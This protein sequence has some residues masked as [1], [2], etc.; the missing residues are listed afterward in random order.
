MPS[1]VLLHGIWNPAWWLLPLARRLRREGFEVQLFGYN[2][3]LAGPDAAV[4]ALVRYLGRLGGG[5]VSLVGHSLGGLVA[6]EA[7]RRGAPGVEKIV[8]LGSPL[9][10]SAAARALC[11]H[12]GCAWLLGRSRALLLEGV[13]PW[14]GK[15]AV[16]MI[17]GRRAAGLGRL[18]AG[19]GES[20]G[21]VA[22]AETRLPG[23][24]DHC[25]VDASHTGLTFSAEAARRV[26]GFLREGRFD[27]GT[28]PGGA[29]RPIG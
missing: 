29:P 13:A 26:A 14:T 27:A 21:T 6:L 8:C 9:L 5:P 1:V 15:A 12:R 18:F 19:L 22:L 3:A 4:Q 20:D 25:V 23:L 17:A 16:G 2:G 24:A 7:A 11:G 28:A 10:G